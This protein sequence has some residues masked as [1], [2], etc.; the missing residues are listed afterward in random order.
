MVEDNAV[1]QLRR[2]MTLLQRRLRHELSPRHGLSRS[3]LKVLS[4]I[5]RTPD[6]SPRDVSDELQM[7]SSNV[8]AALRESPRKR[9]SQAQK[10]LQTS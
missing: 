1:R 2:Q 6:V 5:A 7:T 3:A 10:F 4:A 9:M 8:A